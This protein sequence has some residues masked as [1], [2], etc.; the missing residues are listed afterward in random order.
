MVKDFFRFIFFILF[1][2]FL[3]IIGM[4]FVIII[5]KGK[6]YIEIII[7]FILIYMFLFWKI[8]FRQSKKKLIRNYKSE[9]NKARKHDGKTKK[10]RFDR[11]TKETEP[12]VGIPDASVSGLEQ[13]QGRE[14]LQKADVSDAG[15]NRKGIRKFLRRRRRRQKRK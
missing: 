13:P 1:L 15:K 2:I 8:W 6:I 5:F 3:L 11:G 9:D 12:A 10:G 7:I 14:L 4:V